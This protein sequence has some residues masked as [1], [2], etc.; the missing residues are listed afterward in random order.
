MARVLVRTRWELHCPT[1]GLLL[2]WAPLPFNEKPLETQPCPQCHVD[3]LVFPY[4]W[5]P[6]WDSELV[7][8]G[9]GHA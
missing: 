4:P 6:A 9:G 5:F 8:W 1:C 7:G 3:G 2:V